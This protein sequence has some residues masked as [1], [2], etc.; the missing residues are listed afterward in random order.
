MTSVNFLSTSYLLLLIPGLPLL[1]AICLMSGIL[2]RSALLFAPWAALPALLTTLFLAL[3][4]TLAS[5]IVI[6]LP[7]LLLGTYLGFDETAKM[8]LVF[9]TLVW[10]AA[11]VYSIGYFKVPADK[12]RFLSGFY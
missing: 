3:A 7:W 8:F 11:G 6:K 10:L 4:P 5:E 1:L 12:L 9:T 2:R